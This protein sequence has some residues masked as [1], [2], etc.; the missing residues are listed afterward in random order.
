MAD[1]TKSASGVSTVPSQVK[2]V[3]IVAQVVG[4]LLAAYGGVLNAWQTAHQGSP[5]P[6]VVIAIA[7]LATLV[8]THFGYVRS[9]TSSQNVIVDALTKVATNPLAIALITGFV[10]KKALESSTV[11]IPSATSPQFQVPKGSGTTGTTSP[12][13]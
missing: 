11:T 12:P 13:L 4:T 3:T 7:G 8:C 2:T 1:E 10:T 5:W 9:E 6:G